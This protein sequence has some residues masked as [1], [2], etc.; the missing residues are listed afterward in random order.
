MKVNI[1]Q[2]FY[3]LILTEVFLHESNINSFTE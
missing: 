1:K 2:Y 3:Y